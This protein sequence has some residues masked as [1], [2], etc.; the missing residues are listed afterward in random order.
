MAAIAPTPGRQVFDR[1]LS[2]R[3]HD[4]VSRTQAG[5]LG[6]EETETSATTISSSVLTRAYALLAIE[7]AYFHV[8]ATRSRSEARVSSIIEKKTSGSR[9]TPLR[10][11]A[12][13]NLAS[14]CFRSRALRL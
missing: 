6:G 4:S 3:R 1:F 12:I 13:K 9:L 5:N 11:N 2:S 7:R 10:C 14:G 8:R